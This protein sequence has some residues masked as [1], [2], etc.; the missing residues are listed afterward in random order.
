MTHVAGADFLFPA[1]LRLG[2]AR[3]VEAVRDRLGKA[4]EGDG[5]FDEAGHP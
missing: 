4:G 5:L 3:M 2:G 1:G